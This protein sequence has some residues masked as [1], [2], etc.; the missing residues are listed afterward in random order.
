MENGL[1][2]NIEIYS[3]KHWLLIIFI[4]VL[5]I[6]LTWHYLLGE[7]QLAN[8]ERKENVRRER[9]AP[10]SNIRRK[11]GRRNGADSGGR[12]GPMPPST[13]PAIRKLTTLKLVYLLFHLSAYHYSFLQL[14]LQYCVLFFMISIESN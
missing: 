10:E 9:W 12:N 13:K 6:P 11:E 4:L 1:H 7:N 8:L 2:P 14:I 3:I 5:Q